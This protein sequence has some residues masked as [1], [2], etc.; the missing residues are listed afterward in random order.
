M[1]V[2]VNVWNGYVVTME[3]L[4]TSM[5]AGTVIVKSFPFVGNVKEPALRLTGWS[6]ISLSKP[7]APKG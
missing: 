5:E 6:E 7:I 2:N 1:V 4:I 3:P